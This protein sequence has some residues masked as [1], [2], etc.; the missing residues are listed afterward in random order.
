MSAR[1]IRIDD[2]LYDYIR[3]V[4]VPDDPILA[5]LRARTAELPQ[6]G[7]QISPEQGRFLGFLVGLMGARNCLEIG[8]FTGYS[9]LS[10]ARALPADG[11]LVCCDVSAEWTALARAAWARA[12]VARRID[13]RLGPALQTLETL[14]DEGAAGRFDLAFIDADKE[15]YAAYYEACLT[16]VRPGGVVAIDNVLWGG[17]VADPD[18]DTPE[19]RAIRALNDAVFADARV[20]ACL[21]PIGDGLTLA[22]KV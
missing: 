18:R 22:R 2:R 3:R 21:V 13:L 16:L 10:M 7:M 12:G 15:N 9:A 5:D 14:L 8:T 6:A 4:M 11:R 17:S 20:H 19:T 1:T